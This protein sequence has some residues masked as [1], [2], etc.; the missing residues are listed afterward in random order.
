MAFR[1]NYKRGKRPFGYRRRAPLARVKR[2]WVQSL[3]LDPCDPQT[4]P[5]CVDV[6]APCCTTRWEQVILDNAVLQSQFSDRARVVRIVGDVLIGLDPAIRSD[7]AENYNRLSAAYGSLYVQ[8]IKRPI[9]GA[10][11]AELPRTS[12]TRPR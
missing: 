8:L 6:E 5:L 7:A 2:T 4:I 3:L 12:G 10:G 11:N 9:S 1:R